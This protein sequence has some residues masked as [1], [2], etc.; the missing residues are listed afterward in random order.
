MAAK[1]GPRYLQFY[2][3]GKANLVKKPTSRWRSSSRPVSRTPRRSHR[4]H[5]DID[6]TGRRGPRDDPRTV[7]QDDAKTDFS[8]NAAR[9]L[10]DLRQSTAEEQHFSALFEKQV[11][12]TDCCQTARAE[13]PCNDVASWTLPIREWASSMAGLEIRDLERTGRRRSAHAASIQVHERRWGLNQTG[14]PFKGA[15]YPLKERSEGA[16]YRGMDELD[17][18]GLDDA[19]FMNTFQHRFTAACPTAT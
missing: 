6:G 11:Y 8:R 4:F 12:R 14:T 13:A 19:G 16:L 5:R 2:D 9:R 10:S 17:G 15:K 3:H 18:R 1:F 7:G